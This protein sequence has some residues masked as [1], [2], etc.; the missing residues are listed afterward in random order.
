VTALELAMEQCIY[1]VQQRDDTRWHVYETGT[2]RSLASFG[3]KEDAVEYARDLARLRSPAE[4]D[5]EVV[6]MKRR[7]ERAS[8]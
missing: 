8:A 2:A 1:S 5:L 7:R 6:E 3:L 4:A